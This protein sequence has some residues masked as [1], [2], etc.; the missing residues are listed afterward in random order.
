MLKRQRFTFLAIGGL[1]LMAAIGPG[2]AANLTVPTAATVPAAGQGTVT[3]QGFTVTAIDWT[4]DDATTN[5]E[6]VR[7][8]IERS[9]A[10]AAAVTAAEDEASG[11]AIVRVRLQA[12]PIGTPQS[13]VSCTVTSS[14]SAGS[15]VCDTSAPTA[16][17]TASDLATVNIIAFD[18]N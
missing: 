13:F 4:V 11:N 12:D 8:T 15:A 2:L 9:E 3:V 18:R 7:F 16:T 6:E 1:G 17:M 14:P 5:V 10:G